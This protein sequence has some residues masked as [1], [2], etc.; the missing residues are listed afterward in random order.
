MKLIVTTNPYQARR[1][2]TFKGNNTTAVIDYNISIE[3]GKNKLQ[4]LA[5]D[6][7][8]NNTILENGDVFDT[9]NKHIIYEYSNKSF[10]DD[11]YYFEL[12]PNNFRTV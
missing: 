9:L 12:V 3:Q 11:G 10:S 8:C 4:E 7:G 2:V 6:S 5:L 1:S